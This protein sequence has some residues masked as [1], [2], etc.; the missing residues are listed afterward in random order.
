VWS[1]TPSQLINFSH[2]LLWGTIFIVLLAS[3]ISILNSFSPVPGKAVAALC[4]VLAIPCLMIGWRWIVL[5]STKYELTTQRL[6]IRTGVFSKHLE[7]LELYRV[8]DYKLDQP[9][10]QRLFSLSTIT[11]QTSDKSTPFIV[12]KAIKSGEA[13]REQM[14]AHVETARRQRGVREIDLDQG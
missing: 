5:A 10:F 14:R 2:Y 4:V 1:G 3:G 13:M 7:E 11:L 12:L 8:R 6:R 9:F